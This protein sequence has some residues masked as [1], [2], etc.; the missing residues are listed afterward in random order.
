[1][2]GHDKIRQLPPID[3]TAIALQASGS[4]SRPTSPHLTSA[5]TPTGIAFALESPRRRHNTQEDQWRSPQSNSLSG[6]A[7]PKGHVYGPLPRGPEYRS[8][9]PLGRR[10]H[11]ISPLPRYP[12]VF[13]PPPQLYRGS[14]GSALSNY[15]SQTRLI[16]WFNLELWLAR[17]NELRDE[18]TDPRTGACRIP[19]FLRAYIPLLIWA[20]VSI[21]CTVVVLVWHEQVFNGELSHPT[22]PT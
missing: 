2:A 8:K 16:D 21:A 15:N 1:M 18:A 9:S 6:D 4:Q 10:S 13:S 22:A 19:P 7:F 20:A 11:S 17:V 12:A 14:N 5:A 3:T